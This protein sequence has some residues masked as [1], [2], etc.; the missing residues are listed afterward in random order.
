MQDNKKYFWIKL[1]TDFFNQDT[2]DFL[3]SQSNGCEYVVLY[4]MLCLKTANNN[5]V[6]STNIGEIIVPY[7]VD[8]I[9]RDTKYFSEDTIRVAFELYKKLGLIY[10]G[11]DDL[12]QIA[13]I[14]DMVGSNYNDDHYKEQNRIRQQRYRDKQKLLNS[15]VTVTDEITL[16]RN[17][18]YRDKSIDIRDID[19]RYIDNNN[20]KK[21]IIKK[22]KSVTQEISDYN[23]IDEE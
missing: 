23:W 10:E 17:I 16:N 22:E 20:K 18:E 9:A 3:L 1:K 8:K 11:K 21:N 6:L 13:N 2:I 4:Q 5:G 12:L 14:D 15:N 19:N 7:D